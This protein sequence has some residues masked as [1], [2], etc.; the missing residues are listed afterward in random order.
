MLATSSSTIAP[1]SLRPIA[2]AARVQIG[3]PITQIAT[4]RATS[5]RWAATG[6]VATEPASQAM[7]SDSGTPSSAPNVPGAKGTRPMPPAV[8]ASTAGANQGG[9][10][11]GDGEPGESAAAGMATSYRGG[12]AV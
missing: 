1:G 7:P 8:A 9:L 5:I 3:M 4:T 2:A 12:R 10:A 6:S 11:S